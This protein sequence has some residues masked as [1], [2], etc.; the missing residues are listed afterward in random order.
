MVGYV[1]VAVVVIALVVGKVVDVVTVA[2]VVIVEVVAQVVDV[3]TVA[4]VVV[5]VGEE[6]A[7]GWSL[8]TKKSFFGA[9]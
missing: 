2:V 4:V 6:R 8:C 5:D 1:I 3:V 7:Y 9:E